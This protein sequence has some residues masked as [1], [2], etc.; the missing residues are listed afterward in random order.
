MPTTT[1]TAVIARST[2]PRRSKT[3]YTAIAGP[4]GNGANPKPILS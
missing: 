2:G 4:S 3:V 1:S